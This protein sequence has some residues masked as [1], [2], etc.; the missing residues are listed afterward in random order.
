MTLG[1]TEELRNIEKPTLTRSAMPR[2]IAYSLRVH[3]STH[4]ICS[5]SK[6][7]IKE[8]VSHRRRLIGDEIGG[9][10]GFNCAVVRDNLAICLRYGEERAL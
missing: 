9:E 7:E 2:K 1:R 10:F 3:L 6:R 5:P 4:F 8:Q